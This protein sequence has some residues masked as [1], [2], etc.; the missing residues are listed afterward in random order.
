MNVPYCL[1]MRHKQT[2]YKH[3]IFDL[4][5]VYVYKTNVIK[6]KAFLKIFITTNK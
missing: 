1:K 2:D 6:L 4:L 5:F 3:I